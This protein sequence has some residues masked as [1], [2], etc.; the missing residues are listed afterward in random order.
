MSKKEGVSKTFRFFSIFSWIKTIISTIGF[1]ISTAVSIFFFIILVSILLTLPSFEQSAGNVEII[2]IEGIIANGQSASLLGQK[3]LQ[4]DK[5]IKELKQADK[6]PNTKAI[7]LKIDS[8]G[9]APV[10]SY[11]LAQA[12]KKMNKPVIAVIGETGASGAYWVATAANKI[13]ANPMS[14]T[15]SIGVVASHLEFAGLLKKYNVTYR[16]LVA[17]KYKDAGSAYK[18]MTIDEQALYQKLLDKLHEQ[19]ITAVA[20]NRKLPVDK[21]KLL[22]DGFVFLGSEAKENGLVDELGGIDDAIGHIEQKL[23]ITVQTFEYKEKLGV[24]EFLTGMLDKQSFQL[25]QGFGAIFL[26][27]AKTS[28]TV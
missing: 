13:Y 3:I 6:T 8:P 12:V 18:E 20:Q 22:A 28:I 21:I 23:N 11:D 9:G 2:P 26:T 15:G 4:A 17:G 25:G 1:L 16:R 19:F 14:I 7:I 10:A 27:Q 24:V 5:I